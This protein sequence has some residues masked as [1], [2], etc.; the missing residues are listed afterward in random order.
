MLDLALAGFLAF[1]LLLG[2]KRPFLWVLCYLYVDILAPQI[3]SL[4]V[5]ALLPVSQ[6]VFL[7]AFGGWIL[8]DRKENSRFTWRQGLMIALLLYCGYTTLTATY[9]V[10]AAEKWSWVWKAMLFAIFLPLTLH[11]RLRI[12]SVVLVMVLTASAL[13]IDGGLKTVLG[14]GGYDS[15]RFFVENNTGLYEGSIISCVAIAIIPLTLWLAKHGTIFP[16]EWRVWTFAGALIFACALIPVG[17]QAR[18]GLICLALLCALYLRTAK[19]RFLISMSMSAAML[20]AVPFLPQSFT[21]RMNTIENHKGDQSANT[22]LAVWGWTLGYVKDHPLGGGFEIYIGNTLRFE[23][24]NTQTAGSTTLVETTVVE[25][26]G[27]AFHSSYFEMLGEQ[28]IPGFLMWILLQGSGLWQMEMI[29]R[30]YRKRTEPDAQWQGPLAVA[31]QQAHLVYLAGSL[32][33]GIAFQPFILMLISLQCGFW[34]YLKRIEAP[35]TGKAAR[36][37]VRR[38][39]R[40]RGDAEAAASREAGPHPA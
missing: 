9:A 21:A 4:R 16:P 6:I 30:R 19:H 27:R 31:L 28:G 13:I 14:G 24:V 18:T 1:F 34:S 5:L 2:F 38:E 3:I 22:R 10:E 20:L 12:E 25:D 37:A 8:L 23:T 29:R 40:V 39:M 32:F 11:T 35:A 7:A 36:T 33:V 17:T 26:S 15:L